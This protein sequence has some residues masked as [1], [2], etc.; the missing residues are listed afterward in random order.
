MHRT[1]SRA[2]NFFQEDRKIVGERQKRVTEKEVE[3]TRLLDGLGE[4][5]RLRFKC[6]D[7]FID[8]LISV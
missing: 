3:V 5:H 8:Q 7:L 2:E 4:I 1:A 6:R